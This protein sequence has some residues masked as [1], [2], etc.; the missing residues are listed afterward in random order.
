MRVSAAWQLRWRSG[1]SSPGGATHS[2]RM[3][4]YRGGQVST[5]LASQ[6]SRGTCW[7]SQAY[8]M[9]GSEKTHQE[10]PKGPFLPDTSKWSEAE[11]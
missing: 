6:G 1:N 2:P 7:E 11:C 4:E 10:D 8:K 9:P 3:Q 5:G